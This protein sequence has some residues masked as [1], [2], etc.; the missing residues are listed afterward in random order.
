MRHRL[1]VVLAFVLV[2]V[3]HTAAGAS[4]NEQLFTAASDGNAEAIPALLAAG[5]D[6]N[7]RDNDGY[8]PLHSAAYSG[9]AGAIAALRAAGADPNARNN[10]GFTPLHGAAYYGHAEAIAALHAAGA[11]PNTQSNTG[12]TALHNAAHSGHVEAIAALHTAGADP[13]TGNNDGFTPLHSAAHNGQVEAIAALHVAG[14]DPNTRSKGGF[15][16]L[17]L[18]A[19]NGHNE[20]IAALHEAGAAL[21]AENNDGHT[22]LDLAVQ[23]GHAKLLAALHAVSV[24]EEATGIWSASECGG[25]DDMHLVNASYALIV[26]S[27]EGKFALAI[28]PAEWAGGAVALTHMDGVTVLRTASLKR[29]RALPALAYVGFGEVI[30][31]FQAYDGIRALCEADAPLSCASAVFAMLDISEDG[32]LSEAELARVVRASSVLLTY[33]ILAEERRTKP[34]EDGWPPHFVPAEKLFG[35]MAVTVFG[36]PFLIGN[37]VRSYDYDGDGFLSLEEILQ[38]RLSDDM[39]GIAENLAE[40]GIAEAGTTMMR[41]V[42]NLIGTLEALLR[43][44]F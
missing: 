3:C 4:L 42:P 39:A 31:L 38:D 43:G 25:G 44:A 5:A 12:I 20:A 2:V 34:A 37:L 16:A 14:A 11:D 35:T 9:H 8:V 36:A 17:H 30:T 41:N 28:V 29:C 40:A 24:P 19:E 7:A 6:L 22:A 1:P 33:A 15:T 26:R 27:S 32:H 10:N 23:Q 13:N 21:N 18:A